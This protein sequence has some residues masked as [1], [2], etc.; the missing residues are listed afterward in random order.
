MN[1]KPQGTMWQARLKFFNDCNCNFLTTEYKRFCVCIQ[2]E[3][4]N[5]YS[6]FCDR[7]QKLVVGNKDFENGT[8]L[9]GIN[10]FRNRIVRSI[11]FKPN[12]R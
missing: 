8:F 9:I 1:L 12:L 10:L 7:V 5:T 4:I 3:R 6:T 2:H 11:F